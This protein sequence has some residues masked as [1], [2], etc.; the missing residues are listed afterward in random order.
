MT[1]SSN[2]RMRK[3]LIAT[4]HGLQLYVAP[5]WFG[6]RLRTEFPQFE[7]V[8]LTNYEHIQNEIADAEILFSQLLNAEQFRAAN[9]LQWIH[10]PSA[11]VHQFLFPELIQS[12]VILTNGRE[13]HAPV[14]AEHV[15]ALMF[16]H[17]RRIPESVRF[18]RSHVWGQSIFWDE[19]QCP[20]EIADATIGLV[21]LGSIGRNVAQRASAMGAKIIAVREHADKP[22]PAHVDEVFPSSRLQDMLANADYVVLSPP[23]TS[24]TRGMIGRKQ[25]AAMKPGAYLV[26]VGRGPLIDEAA[27]IDALREGKISGAALDVFDQEP[28][29]PESPLWDLENLLI[30]PHTGGMTEKMWDRHFAVFSENLRRYIAGQPLLAVVDKHSGY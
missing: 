28:L 25:L 4:Q 23:L 21:G 17:A 19:H 26:N 6:D 1:R 2:H 15:M 3:L 29:P 24:S 30:T 8:R 22:K 10:S 7:V 9:N 18:Q 12:D 20:G 13:V 14:V 16:A 11:A 27:L 5:E